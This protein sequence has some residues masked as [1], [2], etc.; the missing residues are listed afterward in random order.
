[1]NGRDSRSTA[2]EAA[3]PKRAAT[4]DTEAVRGATTPRELPELAQGGNER[5]ELATRG[6]HNEAE[7]RGTP[8][9]PNWLAPV[10]VEWACQLQRFEAPRSAGGESADTIPDVEEDGQPAV[11]A[12]A[13]QHGLDLGQRRSMSLKAPSDSRPSSP[14]LP[15]PRIQYIVEWTADSFPPGRGHDQIGCLSDAA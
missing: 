11:C 3:L 1:M 4:T 2:S 14:K 13:L 9:E 12:L 10:G 6:L 7:E 15:S 8:N 5:V